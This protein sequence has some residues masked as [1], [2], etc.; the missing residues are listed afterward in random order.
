MIVLLVLRFVRAWRH[1]RRRLVPSVRAAALRRIRL[2]LARV[3]TTR[4][5][6]HPRRNHDRLRLRLDLSA[7]KLDLVLRLRPRGGERAGTDSSQARRDT[8]SAARRGDTSRSKQF[9]SSS[10]KGQV[11]LFS[12]FAAA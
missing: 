11:N 1:R 9:K 10:D 12:G 6:L 8:S 2:L 3:A 7:V 4:H 5:L